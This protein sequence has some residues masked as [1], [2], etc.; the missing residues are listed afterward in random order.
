MPSPAI[1]SKVPIRYQPGDFTGDHESDEKIIKHIHQ[2]YE[3]GLAPFSKI[4]KNANKRIT[5]IYQTLVNE[6]EILNTIGPVDVYTIV[7]SLIKQSK[8]KQRTPVTPYETT[9]VNFAKVIKLYQ[10][11]HSQQEIQTHTKCS[12]AQVRYITASYSFRL[13]ELKSTEKIKLRE[14]KLNN[15]HTANNSNNSIDP[16]AYNIQDRLDREAI[17]YQELYAR[18]MPKEI[19]GQLFYVVKIKQKADDII[20]RQGNTNNTTPDDILEQEVAALKQEKQEK[21]KSEIKTRLIDEKR[22][23]ERKEQEQEL[24]RL[25]ERELAVFREENES[26]E[27]NLIE[28]SEFEER[29]VQRETNQKPT[30]D[31]IPDDEVG[32]RILNVL[33]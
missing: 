12:Q 25:E 29:N 26:T 18:G 8:T 22:E 2:M 31:T 28:L 23:Q 19:D 16:A 11:G 1:R 24:Q 4:I 14:Q 20:S 3:I 21:L 30:I 17:F 15:R 27:A 5:Q 32:E 33:E 7:L 13:R 9:V 10:D 6:P